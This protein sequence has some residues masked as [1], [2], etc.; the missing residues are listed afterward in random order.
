[1][2]APRRTLGHRAAPA[3]RAGRGAE[4]PAGRAGQAGAQLAPAVPALV[5]VA[6][7]EPRRVRARA[8]LRAGARR[9]RPGGAVR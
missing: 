9:R 6:A 8:P 2:A 7:V 3:A 4:R 5:P 1:M